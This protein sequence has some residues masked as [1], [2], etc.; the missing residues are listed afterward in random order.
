MSVIAYIVTE[1]AVVERIYGAEIPEEGAMA[2]TT[3]PIGAAVVSILGEEVGQESTGTSMPGK[4]C[5][6]R[7]E[8]RV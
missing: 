4:M 1:A 5:S 8:G 7:C 3:R 6:V 2:P